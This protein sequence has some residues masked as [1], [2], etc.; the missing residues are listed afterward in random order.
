MLVNNLIPKTFGSIIYE[1]FEFVLEVVKAMPRA[2][3]IKR[4]I[5]GAFRIVPIAIF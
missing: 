5:K 2:Y 1:G 3:I 4:D